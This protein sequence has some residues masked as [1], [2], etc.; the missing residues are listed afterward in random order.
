MSAIPTPAPVNGISYLATV[1]HLHLEDRFLNFLRW[2]S[3]RGRWKNFSMVFT[4]E[5]RKYNRR[6]F[7]YFWLVVFQHLPE[8]KPVPG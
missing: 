6:V 5:Y 8:K 2:E 3:S 1:Q 4:T 7:E